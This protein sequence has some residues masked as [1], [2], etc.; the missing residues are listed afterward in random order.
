MGGITRAGV[1]VCVCGGGTGVRGWVCSHL[2]KCSG[3]EGKQHV[4]GM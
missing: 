1:F 2:H 4:N 3:A